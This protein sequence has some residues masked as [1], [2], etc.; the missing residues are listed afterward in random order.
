M[1]WHNPSAPLPS[2]DP[3]HSLLH[4]G[5]QPGEDSEAS[6]ELLESRLLTVQSPIL[7]IISAATDVKFKLIKNYSGP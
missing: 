4:H 1:Q 6:Q 3:P 2:R 5:A 7:G